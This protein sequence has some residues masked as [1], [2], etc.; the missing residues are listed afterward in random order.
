M[1][2]VGSGGALE[3]GRGVGVVVGFVGVKVYVCVKFPAIV[4]RLVCYVPWS[5]EECRIKSYLEK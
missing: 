4:L 3:R 1:L 2:L 5:A